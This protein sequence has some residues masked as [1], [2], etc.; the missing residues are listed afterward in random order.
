MATYE[1]PYA[2]G[3]PINTKGRKI[4]DGILRMTNSFAND[5]KAKINRL[6]NFSR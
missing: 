1:N 6:D 2:Q 4:F 5:K 3:K